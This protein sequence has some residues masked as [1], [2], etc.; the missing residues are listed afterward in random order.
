MRL[1]LA[2]ICISTLTS[3][4]LAELPV[5]LL[6]SV[7]PMGGKIGA[8]TE[9]TIAGADLDEADSLHFSHPGITATLKSPNHF[10][11]KI[12]P[13]VAVGNYDVRVV[14]KLGVSNPRTF[15]AGDRP[16]LT[17]TKAHDKP[18]A[19]V[20]VPLGSVFNISHSPQRMLSRE[21]TKP[22]AAAGT[23]KVI[24]SVNN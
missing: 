18:E 8:E 2:L 16:E 3:I 21:I 4:G 11:V 10:T 6:N 17:R 14:G 12:A 1:L 20:E 19:A 5:P 24:L 22:T 7:T 13:E 15:V 23:A 9:V